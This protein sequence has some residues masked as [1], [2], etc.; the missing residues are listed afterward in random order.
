[1]SNNPHKKHCLTLGEL[2]NHMIYLINN[3][4]T[5]MGELQNTKFGELINKYFT[6]ANVWDISKLLPDSIQIF[7]LETHRN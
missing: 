1:M 6:K 2:E 5:N 7:F 4:I 3:G